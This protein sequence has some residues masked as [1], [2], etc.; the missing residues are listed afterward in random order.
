MIWRGI[1]PLTLT[2]S[3]KSKVKNRREKDQNLP[4]LIQETQE[5][6]KY[7]IGTRSLENLEDRDTRVIL[8]IQAIQEAR[9]VI[10]DPGNTEIETVETN[11]IPTDGIGILK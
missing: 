7:W 2:T 6:M 8:M 4:I 3:G 9:E 5:E 10:I 11:P 1:V